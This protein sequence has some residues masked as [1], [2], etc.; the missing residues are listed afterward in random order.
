MKPGARNLKSHAEDLRSLFS[1]QMAACQMGLVVYGNVQ[2]TMANALN[3][4]ELYVSHPEVLVK[5]YR[6]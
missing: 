1:L 4:I 3:S 5:Q 2:T 6:D